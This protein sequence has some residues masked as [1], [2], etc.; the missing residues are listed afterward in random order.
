[1]LTASMI[2]CDNTTG[3]PSTP[4]NPDGGGG[5]LIQEE[6]ATTQWRDGFITTYN[7]SG[8]YP[9]PIPAVEKGYYRCAPSTDNLKGFIM[10]QCYE[11]D[12]NGKKIKVIA[13]DLCP[14]GPQ[15]TWFDLEL[16]GFQTLT[17]LTTGKPNVKW[18]EIPYLT[19]KNISAKV[20]DGSSQW[21][22]GLYILGGRYAVAKVELS[23]DGKT[24]YAMEP[25]PYNAFWKLEHPGAYQNGYRT[26]LNIRITDRYNH[27]INTQ[28]KAITP[29][30]TFDLG[31]NFEY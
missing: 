3:E 28:L 11:L 21:W 31:Q 14:D 16:D 8:D 15:A 29:N 12:Y 27:V 23:N 4:D 25:E 9:W 7:K 20:K 18:R 5:Q 30:Q 13:D 10:G 2:A 17:G 22:I 24:Y 6:S 26:P 19:D 1:M